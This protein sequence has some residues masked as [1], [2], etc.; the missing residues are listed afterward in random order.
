VRPDVPR[1]G[2]GLCSGFCGGACQDG[3][4]SGQ[5]YAEPVAAPLCAAWTMPYS[6]LTIWVVRDFFAHV[7]V[8]V[9][10]SMGIAF[11]ISSLTKFIKLF[12]MFLV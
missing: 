1:R 5:T 11:L 9:N 6:G 10:G 2:A 12:E 8:F 3:P 7:I 4:I